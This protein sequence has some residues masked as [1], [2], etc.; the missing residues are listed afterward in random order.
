PRGPW[1][2]P[3]PR[4][5]CT[6]PSVT[7][8]VC[9]GRAPPRPAARAPPRRYDAA[10]RPAGLRTTQLSLLSRLE[11][12]GPLTV[13]RLA[14]RLGLDRTSLTRGLAVLA[15]RGPVT[16]APRSGRRGGGRRV[17]PAAARP[18]PA[19]PARGWPPGRTG[20]R[21][22]RRRSPASAA[23]ARR[24]CST[25]CAPSPHWERRDADPGAPARRL[26]AACGLRRGARRPRRR[27]PSGRL[28][29]R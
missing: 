26:G 4:K 25:T 22:R 16:V 11:D 21:P 14:A 13:S 20:R 23:S 19:A 3:G 6:P 8:A 9:R 18:R 1:H 29:S 17:A 2:A 27:D 7:P 12:E 24:A 10:L 28:R 15:G 5:V